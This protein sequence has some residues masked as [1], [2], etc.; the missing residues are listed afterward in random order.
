M[1]LVGLVEDE[2]PVREKKVAAPVVAAKVAE[3]PKAE[4][5]PVAKAEEAAA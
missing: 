2:L 3:A 1:A 5:A 4:E